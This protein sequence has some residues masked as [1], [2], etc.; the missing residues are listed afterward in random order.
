[1]KF[2]F[3]RKFLKN[4]IFTIR[5]N[6]KNYCLYLCHRKPER[7]LKIFGLDRYLCARCLGLCIGLMVMIFFN[8]VQIKIPIFLTLFFVSFLIVDGLSQLFLYR[9]S[10]NT[11]RLTSGI[12]FPVGLFN[13]LD[14]I[15]PLMS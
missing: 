3:I 12:V 14:T 1:M 15:V 11:L 2:H 10:T 7:S 9:E 4:P 13:L 6:Q 8:M 5:I